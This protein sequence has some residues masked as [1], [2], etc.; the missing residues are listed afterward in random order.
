MSETNAPLSNN[1]PFNFAESF[2]GKRWVLTPYDERKAETIIQRHSLGTVAAQ[3]LANRDINISDIGA[4][5]EPRLKYYLS[6]IPTLKG[7][8]E[9]AT[10]IEKALRANESVC[11][12]GDYDVDGATSSA[13]MSRFLTALG[14]T[15]HGIYIPDR[16]T[17][18]YGPNNEALQS[19]KNSGARLVI[20]LDCGTTAF[21]QA[22]FARSIGLDVL[23]ID[24]HAAEPKLPVALAVINPNRMDE[25]GLLGHLAA[26]GVTFLTLI[27][28]VKHLRTTDFFHTCPEPDLMGL[29]DIVALGTVADVVPL[30]TLNRAFVAQ[31]LKIMAK[32]QNIGIAA[33]LDVAEVTS[34]PQAFHLGFV[35][36]PRI[37]AGGRVGDASLGAKLLTET[38]PVKAR[39]IAT[40][41]DNHND[42]RKEIEKQT[43]EQAIHLMDEQS[44]NLN[45]L[46]CVA[47]KDWHAGVIGIVAARLKERTNRPTFV[48]SIDADGIGKGSGRSINGVDMGAL[49]IAAR[50]NG[51]LVAGGGHKMAA[52]LTVEQDKI[53]AFAK[54]VDGH[55]SKKHGAGPLKPELAIDA[56]LSPQGATVELA[57][58]LSAMEPFGQGNPEPRLALMDC[59]ILKV[60]VLKDVHLRLIVGD[61]MRNGSLT[62][63]AWKAVGTDMGK[64]LMN[65]CFN[66]PVHLAGNLQINEWRGRKSVQFILSDAAPAW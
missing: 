3:I 58:T 18:G 15:N 14:H 40:I 50:Q 8:S 22:D 56:I 47:G 1:S 57:Q 33:L 64:T 51:L 11:I 9:T 46:V 39:D 65:D 37:N 55:I 2:S 42:D 41:L 24:H 27:E 63:M 61:A 45:H 16:M 13:L 60:D 7:S 19:I 52:G 34:A 20:M 26:C 21:E 5:L 59:R 28:T 54:F 17:E 44:A 32:R 38:N 36:G 62:V 29:L 23:I 31:G 25:D 6:N 49:V 30:K 43:L 35:L 4:F 53:P 12:F 10:R 48:I 66:R